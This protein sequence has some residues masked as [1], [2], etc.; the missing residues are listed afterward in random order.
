MI[1]SALSAASFGAQFAPVPGLSTAISVLQQIVSIYENIQHNRELCARL[2]ERSEAVIKVIEL[3]WNPELAVYRSAD[4]QRLT[5]V[6]EEIREKMKEWAGYNL[7]DAFIRQGQISGD[8]D[9]KSKDLDSCLEAFNLASHLRLQAMIEE[10]RTALG[11]DGSFQEMLDKHHENQDQLV[12]IVGELQKLNRSQTLGSAAQDETR[13]RLLKV[14]S[15]LQGGGLPD[16]NLK[17]GAECEKVG[18]KPA[19]TARV[20]EIWEGKWMGSQRV[21]LKLFR[22]LTNDEDARTSR[23]KKRVDREVRI[24]SLLRNEYIVPLYGVC[25][26]DGTY[27]YL[28]MPWYTNGNATQYLKHKASADKLKI[29]LDAARGLKYLHT[30]NRPVVHGNLRGSNIL[31]SDNG[32]GLLS[33]FGFSNI[34]GAEHSN[35]VASDN[36]RWMSFEAQQGLRTPDVDVWAWAMTAVELLSEELPFCDIQMTGKLAMM[37]RD[38]EHPNKEEQERNGIQIDDHVW[39][40]LESCWKKPDRRAKIEVVVAK[41]EILTKA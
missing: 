10:I 41:M 15:T 38:G 16:T 39:S 21:A 8:V 26:D 19:I 4:L 32:R 29:C 1:H 9:S 23:I 36:H 37:I 12:I 2:V 3:H 22:K 18:D 33:D 28:V 13:V 27:P 40:L 35:T 30:L 7:F 5:S 34:A 17:S 31:I 20:H 24:W 14:Q 6:L 25:T 11:P